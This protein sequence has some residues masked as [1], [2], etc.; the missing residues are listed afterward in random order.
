MKRRER[1]ERLWI[2]VVAPA[3]WALHLVL[4][5]IIVALWC[6]RFGGIAS[7]GA[8]QAAIAALTLGALVGITVLFAHG[9][10]RRNPVHPA[11]P[12]DDDSPDDRRHFMAF[13]TM[14]LA[15]MSLLATVFVAAGVFVAG[16]CW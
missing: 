10:R 14:L 15:A 13:T 6:G 3:I 11:G 12:H 16:G 7:Q 1:R 8:V 4:C 9:Y 5:Q 2:P